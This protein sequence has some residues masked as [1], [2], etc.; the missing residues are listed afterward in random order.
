MKKGLLMLMWNRTAVFLLA[1]LV[2]GH[3]VPSRSQ[4]SIVGTNLVS[5]GSFET[6][7]GIGELGLTVGTFHQHDLTTVAG[8]SSPSYPGSYNFVFS[9][10]TVDTPVSHLQA[11]GAFTKVA[12]WG[13]SDGSNNGLGASPDGGDFVGM[14]GNYH[15]ATGIAAGDHVGPLQQTISGLTVGSQ[16]QLSFYWAAAQQTNFVAPTVQSLEVSLGSQT[17]DT[18]SVGIAGK[19]FSGWMLDTMTFTATDTSEVLS[20][21][22]IGDKPYAPFTLLDGVSLT[23]LNSTNPSGS[24]ATPAAPEPSSLLVSILA[25]CV[26]GTAWAIKR[27]RQSATT[28]G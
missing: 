21:L 14:I 3:L 9:P 17:Q 16:Y 18:A 13:P 4:G 20:F 28:G 8:W 25:L 26:F 5:N 1:A 11:M 23:L 24:P 19:G 7:G 15:P 10:S 12:L 27:G 6:N 2:L 22:A